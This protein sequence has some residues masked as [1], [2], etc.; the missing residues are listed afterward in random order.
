LYP[1][2]SASSQLFEAE[3]F[4]VSVDEGGDDLFVFVAHG[5][6]CLKL[7]PEILTKSSLVLGIGSS[8]RSTPG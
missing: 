1:S 6:D 4:D 7:Q 3:L 5:L 8:F 2:I